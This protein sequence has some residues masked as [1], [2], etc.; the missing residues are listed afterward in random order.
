MKRIISLL[1]CAAMLLA[2]CACG[3]AAPAPTP[4]ATPVPTPTPAPTPDPTELALEEF[5]NAMNALSSA[6]GLTANVNVDSERIVRGFSL[7][8]TISETFYA[9]DLQGESPIIRRVQDRSFCDYKYNYEYVFYNGKVFLNSA[10]SSPISAKDYMESLY[11]LHLFEADN[12]SSVRLE[13]EELIFE[14][15][16]CGESWLEEGAELITANARALLSEG[17]ISFISYEA[18]Y[19]QGAVDVSISISVEPV[20]FEPDYTLRAFAPAGFDIAEL[21]DIRI[22]EL[23]ERAYAVAAGSPAQ[24]SNSYTV[25]SVTAANAVLTDQLTID[26]WGTGENTQF[27]EQ[28]SSVI[29]T[30]NGSDEWGYTADYKD[31]IYTTDANGEV[32]EESLPLDELDLSFVLTEY[33]FHPNMLGSMELQELNGYYYIEFS[34]GEELGNYTQHLICDYI[35]GDPYA[36]DSIS[37]SYDTDSYYGW[38]SFDADSLLPVSYGL[39][40]A[41]RHSSG[42]LSY[43]VGLKHYVLCDFASRNACEAVTG[44]KPEEAEPENKATPLF[45]KVSGQDGQEMWLLGTIHAGDERTAYLPESIY[46]A[47]DESAALAVEIDIGNVENA[48]ENDPELLKTYV[49]AQ[50]YSDLSRLKDHIDPELYE[51]AMDM[52]RACGGYLNDATEYMKASTISTIIESCYASSS[53]LAAEKGVDMRLLNLAKEKGIEIREVEELD[54]HLNALYGLSDELQELLLREAVEY[55][56]AEYAAEVE[57]LFELWCQGDEAV[58]TEKMREG[59]ED[60]SEEELPLYEEYIKAMETDRNAI[61][62]NVAVEYLESGETVFFA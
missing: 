36:L 37:I 30:A 55:D 45:Y 39:E 42:A 53:L 34:P 3:T 41:G 5:E 29:T 15:P 22:G 27:K 35:F 7:P 54:A 58:L 24:S 51:A 17:N 6:P 46:T 26:T 62:H 19:K 16:R 13:G 1:L 57:E 10:Y 14:D 61:M 32:T 31:G 59:F 56:R 28:L 21:D 60:V 38:L 23:F 8:E 25:Y 44:E 20:S 33:M 12:F 9:H 49:S 40:Y 2:L 47:L 50:M 18:S 11:V 4:E 43:P 48:M 52:A